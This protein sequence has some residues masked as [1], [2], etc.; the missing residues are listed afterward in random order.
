MESGVIEFSPESQEEEE[1]ETS[2]EELKKW[3]GSAATWG[4]IFW[5]S[6]LHVSF[7]DANFCDLIRGVAD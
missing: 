5:R 7:V 4:P 6:V 1:K 3:L 2:P